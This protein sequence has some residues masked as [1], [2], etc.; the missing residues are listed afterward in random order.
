LFENNGCV[1]CHKVDQKSIGPSLKDIAAAY[2]GKED[3]MFKFL[4]GQA[5]AIVDPAQFAVM[6]TNLEITKKMSDEDVKAIVDY[7]MSVQ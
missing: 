6:Q 3:Q 7:I 5:E 4:K 1:A 2:K